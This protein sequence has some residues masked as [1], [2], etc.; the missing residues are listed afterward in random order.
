MT[1][2]R[3]QAPAAP[4]DQQ[5]EQQPAK[6]ADVQV[7]DQTNYDNWKYGDAVNADAPDEIRAQWWAE[8]KRLQ[9]EAQQ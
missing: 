4:V 5:P 6:Q 2:K 3:K 8:H 1:Y 7:N 9:R